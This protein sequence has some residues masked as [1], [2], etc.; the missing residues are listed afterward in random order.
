MRTGTY[1]D[2][3]GHKVH[4]RRTDT[5]YVIRH[6]EGPDAGTVTGIRASADGEVMRTG[7]RVVSLRG[8]R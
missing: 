2:R 6:L 3:N 8:V 4:V 5:G 7:Q 1:L